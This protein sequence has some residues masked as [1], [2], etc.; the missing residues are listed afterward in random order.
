MKRLH[1]WHQH[2]G[3]Q[4]A[5]NQQLPSAQHSSSAESTDSNRIHFS[6]HCGN[7]LHFLSFFWCFPVAS[8]MEMMESELMAQRVK[9]RPSWSSWWNRAAWRTWPT[10]TSTEAS[11]WRSAHPAPPSGCLS[12]ATPPT[13]S[14]SSWT[15]ISPTGWKLWA[16]ASA[17][18]ASAPS[19]RLHWI[20]PLPLPCSIPS[21]E[22]SASAKYVPFFKNSLSLSF[23]FFDESGSNFYIILPP[24]S[25]GAQ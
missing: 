15:S 2:A 9:W 23:F 3:N 20:G 1:R 14:A 10:A 8:P 17:P 22:D 12:T 11:G 16:T 4:H 6:S 7:L 5:E 18:E 25:N 24:H 21:T 13:C 19:I